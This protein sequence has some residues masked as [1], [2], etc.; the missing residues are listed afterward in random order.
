[1]PDQRLISVHLDFEVEEHLVLS[2]FLLLSVQVLEVA[3]HTLSSHLVS[4]HL[5][6]SQ[7]SYPLALAFSFLLHFLILEE[8]PEQLQLLDQNASHGQH[9]PT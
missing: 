7:A 2:G 5:L 9:L 1:M 6:S 8:Q 3:P 4:L